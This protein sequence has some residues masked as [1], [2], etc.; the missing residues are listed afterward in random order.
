MLGLTGNPADE[1]VV[2]QSLATPSD[3]RSASCMGQA[4][5]GLVRL[6]R[7]GRISSR[8]HR[9]VASWNVH[10]EGIDLLSTLMSS[11]REGTLL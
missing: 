7:R 1:S 11:Y 2:Q 8:A 10:G 6:E 4:G 9:P 3:A 5:V